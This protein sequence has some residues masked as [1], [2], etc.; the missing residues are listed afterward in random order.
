MVTN[1][2]TQVFINRQRFEV[3]EQ[4]LSGREILALADLG[5]GYDLFLLQGEGDP[6]GGECILADQELSIKAGLHF[7]AIP[8][9]CTFGAADIPPPLL[10][11][12]AEELAE[13]LDLRVTIAQAGTEL[14][15]IV[16]RAPLPVHSADQSDVL[17]LVDQQYPVSALDM[18][19]LQPEISLRGGS[20]PGYSSSLESH[21][22]RR[23]RR[24]SWHRNGVWTPGVDGLLSHWAF[25]EACWAREVANVPAGVQ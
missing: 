17:I 8:G 24:W 15:V 20:V 11:A 22:G 1:S 16:W 4:E 19:Y 10:S 9:D 13:M 6:T 3:D 21:V 18:F 12:A 5:A 23:W 7:R 14:G 2:K 25:I